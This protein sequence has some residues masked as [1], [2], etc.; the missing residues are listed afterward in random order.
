MRNASISAVVLL[1]LVA[2]GGD[3][4][5]V[6]PTVT[7]TPTPAPTPIPVVFGQGTG[8]GLPALPEC[9][10]IGGDDGGNLRIAAGRLPI[11]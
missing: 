5:P 3:K 8:C 4:A 11:G 7:A 1:T 9:G 10:Q 6:T 2:C